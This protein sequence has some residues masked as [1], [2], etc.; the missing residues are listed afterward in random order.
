VIVGIGVDVVN[1][2]K[3]GASVARTPGFV[4]ALLTRREQVDEFG[5]PRTIGSLAARFAAK[6]AVAKAIGLPPGRAYR[7]VE[8]LVEP[9]GRPYLVT[10][11]LMRDAAVG[12]GVRCWHL[13]LATEGDVAVAYVVAEGVSTLAGA[14]SVE[15]GRGVHSRE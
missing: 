12:L 6:E 1:I 3:F 7:D 11:G 4:Q 15:P 10:H 5:E 8:V 9:D 2:A 13:S 14:S